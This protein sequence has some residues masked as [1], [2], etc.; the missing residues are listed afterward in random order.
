M[1]TNNSI[2]NREENLFLKW[3]NARK[4]PAFTLDGV[5]DEETYNKQ[6]VKILYILK[7]ANW[8]ECNFV[9]NLKEWLLSEKSSTYW[10][11]WNNIARWTQALQIGGDYISAISKK[12]K[13]YWLRKIAFLELKKVPGG[14]SSSDDEIAEYAKNDS[15]FLKCQIMIY[16]PDIIICCGRG[17]GKNADLLYEYV[18][19]DVEKSK[20]SQKPAA[21]KYNYFF[22]IING[23]EIPVVS[24]VHPQMRGGHKKYLEYY[25]GMKAIR[26]ELL[27]S[28]HDIEK[29]SDSYFMIP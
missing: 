8:K 28:T 3:Q 14:A 11:T 22:A 1:L 9:L 16:N 12:D 10:K 5:F 23:K 26:S 25:N 15:E 4:Y 6:E 29:K 18:F 20:W 2:V 13:T 19:D 21:N 24:F 7:E 27:S 17:N